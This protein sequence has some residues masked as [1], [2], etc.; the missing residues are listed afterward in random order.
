MHDF[1]SHAGRVRAPHDA[2]GPATERIGQSRIG[3]RKLIVQKRMI[4]VLA[5][6]TPRLRECEIDEGAAGAGDDREDRIEDFASLEVLIE[7]EMHQVTQHAPALRNAESHGVA[8]FAADRIHRRRIMPQ[9]RDQITDR[10]ETDAHHLGIP[11]GINELINRAAIEA[12]WPD[13][14]NMCRVNI[15]PRKAGWG[16]ALVPLPLAHRQRRFVSRQIGGLIRQRT[17]E[18]SLRRFLDERIAWTEPLRD[19]LVAIDAGRGHGRKP[20]VQSVRAGRHAGLPG[21]PDQRKAVPHQE[22]VAGMRRGRRAIAVG[23]AIEPGQ[24][25][26]VAAVGHVVQQPAI[27]FREV[28]RRHQREVGTVLHPSMGVARRL[29]QIDDHGIQRMR[30][31]EFAMDR[32]TQALV[33]PDRAKHAPIE[34]RRQA[35]GDF[36]I[37]YAAGLGCHPGS[38]WVADQTITFVRCRALCARTAGRTTQ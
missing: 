4:F 9:E 20:R 38:P 16:D 13:N 5:G 1:R 21:A 25:D 24:R 35:L 23:A 17:N 27:A 18:R 10:G 14:F 30:R 19:E 33:S 22:S 15:A 31:I 12:G 32:A 8:H 28:R 2:I 29:G 7:A 6:V 34:Y 3:E 37:Q 36:N 11:G 26:L